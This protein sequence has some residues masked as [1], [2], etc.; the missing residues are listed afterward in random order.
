MDPKQVI[1]INTGTEP[2]MRI[3]NMIAQGDHVSM[4]VLLQRLE[5][6]KTEQDIE[7]N[8]YGV[9]KKTLPIIE[10]YAELFFDKYIWDWLTGTFTKI[11]LQCPDTY[12]LYSLYLQAKKEH[13]PS[14][15]IFDNS[16][17]E[18]NGIPTLTAVAIGPG[19][20]DQ[21]NKITGH[22]KLL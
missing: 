19:N 20:S 13:L 6:Y 10:Y 11:V 12:D 14:A 1:I 17:T 7:F 9:K 18:F 2:K 3:G 15:Y 21:I 5:L 22:F 8:Y 4:K 16:Y